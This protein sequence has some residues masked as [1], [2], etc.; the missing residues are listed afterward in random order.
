MK[1]EPKGK[2]NK[3]APDQLQL[4]E[5]GGCLSIFGLP[6]FFAGIFTTLI[7]LGI[8]PVEN[9]SDFPYWS[10]LIIIAMGLI[11]TCVGGVLVFGRRWITID[12]SRGV[13]LKYWGLIV[14]MKQ[15]ELNLHMYDTVLIK[16]KAGDSDS[17]DIYIVA[18]RAKDGNKDLDMYSSAQYGNSHEQAV[19][20][21]EF[22]RFPVID[23]STDHASVIDSHLTDGS[24]RSRNYEGQEEFTAAARPHVMQ[25]QVQETANEIQIV[26][27]D[28]TFKAAKVIRYIL[29]AI[30][31]IFIVPQFVSFFRETNTPDYV[32]YVFLGAAIL[33]LGIIPLVSLIISI[34]RSRRSKTVVTANTEG[35]RIDYSGIARTK[36]KHILKADILGID[37]STAKSI[38][39]SMQRS[40]ANR[41]PQNRSA[42][43]SSMGYTGHVPRWINVMRKFVRS[44]GIIIKSRSNVITF[45]AGLPDEEVAYIFSI[46]KRILGKNE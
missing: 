36:T 45:G 3:V 21:A 7:G 23:N 4:K 31:L 32:E 41:D 8:I 5:G 25:T 39:G 19:L 2:F 42:D 10:R 16:F 6:F 27:P 30:M 14:P 34:L 12:S 15:T 38:M 9:E 20:V 33:F 13:I 22:L 24:Y 44:K 37:Y 29:P 46:I 35:I 26:I 40:V 18:L 43:Y 17:A 1:T 11:F 28:K